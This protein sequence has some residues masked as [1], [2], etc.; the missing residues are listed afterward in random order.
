M[1][2]HRNLLPT[3]L[4]KEQIKS[5]L[6]LERIKHENDC[7]VSSCK[8]FLTCNRKQQEGML[9]GKPVKCIKYRH[10]LR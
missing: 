3:M 4:K 1:L 5:I 8:F 6:N 2:M 9:A 7:K 10:P